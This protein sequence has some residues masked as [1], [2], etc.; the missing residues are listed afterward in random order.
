[1]DDLLSSTSLI[2][3]LLTWGIGLTP[4]L[5]LRYV[6]FKRAI[7]KIAAI[8]ISGVFVFINLILFIALGSQ[9]KSHA[10]LVLVAGVSYFILRS[11]PTKKEF[12]NIGSATESRKIR[13]SDPMYVR[14][15]VCDFEQW[16]NFTNCQKCG[17]HF[18]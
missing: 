12:N 3:F 4:P 18:K 8:S 7:S 14:C 15:S 13:T 11:K 2:S 17:A 1:M 9:S 6:V 10:A 16:E 5:I